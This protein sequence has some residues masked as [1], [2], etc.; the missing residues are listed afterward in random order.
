[1]TTPSAGRTS[2]AVHR[3][4]KITRDVVLAAT[5]AIIDRDQGVHVHRAGH[6]GCL[7]SWAGYA[8]TGQREANTIR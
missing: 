6:Y 3:D 7:S 8:H 1:M 4:A 5:M 2:A